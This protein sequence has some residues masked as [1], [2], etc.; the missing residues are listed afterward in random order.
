MIDDLKERIFIKLLK[1]F[2]TH[3]LDQWERWQIKTKHG[4]VYVSISRQDDGYHWD[5]LKD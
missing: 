3:K 1:W 2:C 5:E 4:D